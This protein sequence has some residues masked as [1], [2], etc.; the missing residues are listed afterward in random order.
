MKDV[1]YT[2]LNT[3]GVVVRPVSQKGKDAV[4]ERVKVYRDGAYISDLYNWGRIETEL[5]ELGLKLGVP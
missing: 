1:L 4:E 5:R 2:V 3:G